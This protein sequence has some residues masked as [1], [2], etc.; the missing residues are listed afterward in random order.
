MKDLI[1]NTSIDSVISHDE[2]ILI[3]IVIKD[4]DDMNQE[5]KNLKT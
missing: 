4:Y 2:F 3:N 5:I 1:S